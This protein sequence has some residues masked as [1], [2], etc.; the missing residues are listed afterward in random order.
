M[1]APPQTPG[2]PREE[3]TVELSQPIE[4]GAA[5]SQRTPTLEQVRGPGAPRVVRLTEDE[6]IVG[7]SL[8]AA[9]S[10]DSGSISRR[11]LALSR[12]DSGYRCTDLDSSNGVFLNGVKVHSA[13]LHDGDTLQLGDAAFVYHE[14]G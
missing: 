8:Q 6:V 3:P 2:R 5:R 14:T 1:T 10:I 12:V 11:H 7:R 9:I 13:L 4:L